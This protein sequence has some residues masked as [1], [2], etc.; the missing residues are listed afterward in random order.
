MSHIGRKVVITG[1]NGSMAKAITRILSDAGYA[2]IN[3]SR[4]FLDV[5]E[6]VMVAKF[7][8]LHRPW[9][10]INCAGYII[11]SLIKDIAL[12]E[13]TRHFE[14]NVTGAFLCAKYACLAGCEVV[15]NIGST[16]AFEGR[17]EWGAYCASKVAL[18]SL[19]ETLAEEG[20]KAYSI[21]PARTNTKMRRGLFPDEDVKTLMHPGAIASCVEEIF[22]GDFKSGSHLIVGKDFFYVMPGRSCPK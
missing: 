1:G 16:S 12:A 18:I 10:L 4:E 13:W 7:M 2:T 19:T 6:E 8:K 22:R 5:T 9:A 21:N 11:P 3:P 20:V 14:V 17:K 15:I